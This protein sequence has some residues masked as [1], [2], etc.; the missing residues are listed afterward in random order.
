MWATRTSNNN[1]CLIQEF[2]GNQN[3]THLAATQVSIA[4]IIE[5]TRRGRA[6]SSSAFPYYCR[7]YG[8]S[9]T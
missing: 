9:K 1:D 5:I 4:T 8:A 6:Q 7:K 3:A 2:S